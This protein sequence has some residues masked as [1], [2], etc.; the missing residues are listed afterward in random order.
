MQR[1]FFLLNLFLSVSCLAITPGLFAGSVEDVVSEVKQVAGEA[2]LKTA[3]VGVCFLPID[4]G[5]ED[6]AGFQMDTGLIPASTMKVFTTA[7]VNELLGPDYRFVTEI[8]M[9]G[10]LD[11]D[12]ML[13]GD[14]IIRGGG[15]PTLGADSTSG[16][17][18]KWK[19]AL[20]KAG[21]KSINGTIVGDASVFGTIL[22]P[23]T[24][25]WNDMGNYYGA[26]ACGLTFHENLFH[27]T[28]GTSS[29][30]AIAP[31]KGTD[32]KL[33]GI[34][35]FNEMRVG[36]S[37]S[38]DQGYIYGDPYGKVFTLRG[39]VPA[40]SGSFSIKGALPDPAYFCARAFSEYLIKNG[41]PVSGE[42][43]TDRI[44]ASAGKE[45][46]ARTKIFDQSSDSLRSLLLTT[47]YKS[48]N[49]KAECMHRMIAVA[50]GKKGTTAAA[51]A[52]TEAHWAEKGVDMTGFFMGDGCGLSRADTVT[53]RQMALMLYYAAKGEHY[54]AFYSSLPTAGQS[55]TL[56][57]I[58][59]GSAAD[60]RVRAKSGTIDRVRNYAGYVN[61][62]SGKRYA[63]AIFINNY[64]GDLGSVKSK[65]VRIWSEMVGL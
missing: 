27:V 35:F 6:A 17:F 47:N 46:P 54:D 19:E 25:Q 37:G 7:T 22:T 32:P 38:G 56:K 48:D 55:G 51:A 21:I 40:G 49:L 15:D 5:P 61:A 20:D 57:S 36:S 41:I 13:A 65:I 64:T 30:G 42:A 9:T 8:Q 60:G 29:V 43:T 3:S 14:V 11:E 4:G 26:A 23:D 58:G 62:R 28:F 59:G 31:V 24:W 63:F 39:S 44:L 52:V 1:K 16:T 33:P 34:E 50:A 10:T 53:P 12:G 45:I 2:G 18:S